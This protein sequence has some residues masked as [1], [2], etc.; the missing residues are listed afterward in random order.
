MTGQVWLSCR[1]AGAATAPKYS[2]LV[3]KLV[4]FNFRHSSCCTRC[5]ADC[6]SFF[7]CLQ[8][9]ATSKDL[10]SPF[11]G[12]G[13]RNPRKQP[14]KLVHCSQPGRQVCCGCDQCDLSH[15]SNYNFPSRRHWYFVLADCTGTV[16]AANKK[17]ISWM[18][19]CA[20]AD[21]H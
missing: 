18:Q 12:K 6:N 16:P 19:N 1:P 3:Q 20:G 21:C 10:S 7:G 17:R 14:N 8:L 9:I 5:Q 15:S 2:W 11:S 13:E 4:Q